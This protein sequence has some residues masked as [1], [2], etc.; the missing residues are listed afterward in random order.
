M[1]RGGE[2]TVCGLWSFG[3]GRFVVAEYV[4]YRR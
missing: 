2:V 3:G 1:C 4:K